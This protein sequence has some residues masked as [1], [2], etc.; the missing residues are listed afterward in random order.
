LTTVKNN[1]NIVVYYVGTRE[2][3]HTLDD[4]LPSAILTS[5]WLSPTA[6]KKANQ[7]NES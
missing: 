4:P 5:N 2:I 1:V 6:T 7:P 3:W